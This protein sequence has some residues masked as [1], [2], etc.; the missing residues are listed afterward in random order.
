VIE[1]AQRHLDPLDALA[2]DSLDGLIEQIG[3]QV[4]VTLLVGE[5]G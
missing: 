4:D 5:P 3:G 1:V 2:L